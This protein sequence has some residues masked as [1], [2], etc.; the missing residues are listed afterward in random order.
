MKFIDLSE[1][2]PGCQLAPCNVEILTCEGCGGVCLAV[3]QT[4]PGRQLHFQCL[5]CSSLLCWHAGRCQLETWAPD[6][7]GEVQSNE[8]GD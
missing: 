2:A 4:R 1:T 7:S 3:F 5:V 8:G 6:L